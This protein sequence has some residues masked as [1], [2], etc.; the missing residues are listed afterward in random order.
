MSSEFGVHPTMIST[1]KQELI[2]RA[3]ELFARGNKA[4][5]AGDAQ[6]VIDDLHR[7]IGQLQG[8]APGGERWRRRFDRPAL[9]HWLVFKRDQ[10]RDLPL[11]AKA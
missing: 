9:L 10:C 6:K 11:S 3:N 7:K 2:K 8:I 5:A 4:P 1:R